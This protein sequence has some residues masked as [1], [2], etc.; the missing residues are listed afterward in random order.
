MENQYENTP[1]SNYGTTNSNVESNDDVVS[2]LNDLIQ[3]CKDGQ[4]GF[5]EAAEGVRRS[6]LKTIF[7]EFSQQ[8]AEF[9]GVLQELVRG[10]GGDPESSGSL[11]GAIHR[12]WMNIKAAVTDKDETAILNECER[13]EDQAK[14]AYADAVERSLPSNVAEVLGQQYHAILS[15]HN[16]VKALRN[17]ESKAAGSIN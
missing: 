4:D 15:A 8:R 11:S 13:G 9:A 6:D 1:V 17:T 5:K 2:L 16:R 7:Y 10:L 12:G 14:D 3:T